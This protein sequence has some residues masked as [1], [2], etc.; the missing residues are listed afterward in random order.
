MTRGAIH[1][2]LQQRTL[3]EM[4]DM[5]VVHLTKHDDIDPIGPFDELGPGH[6]DLRL[7]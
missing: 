5:I 1:Q 7:W 2:V 3:N 6:F 4:T